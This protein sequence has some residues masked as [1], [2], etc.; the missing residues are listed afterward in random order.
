MRKREESWKTNW[1]R[2]K[3]QELISDQWKQGKLENQLSKTKK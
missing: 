3:R 1:I 2:Q